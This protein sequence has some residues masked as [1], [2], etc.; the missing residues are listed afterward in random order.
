MQAFRLWPHWSL[1]ACMKSGDDNKTVEIFRL[2]SAK[3]PVRH[4]KTA[5]WEE[6]RHMTLKQD[7]KSA[8]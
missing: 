1:C 4:L 5:N 7:E 8:L 3:C 6:D 2:F